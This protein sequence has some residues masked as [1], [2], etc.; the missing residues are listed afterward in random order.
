MYLIFIIKLNMPID[1]AILTKYNAAAK[2]CGKVYNEIVDLINGGE[3]NIVVLCKYG[4]DKIIE[5]CNKIYK[6]EQK[7]IGFPVCITLNDCVGNYL[8]QSDKP[9][10]NTIKN[11]DTIKI[12]LAVNIGGCI[13][14]YG[15]TIVRG[16]KSNEQSKYIDLLDQL[17]KDVI[18]T[19]KA[20]EI[21]DDVRIVLESRCSNN[22]CFPVENCTSYQLLDG[23]I[24]TPESKY[25]VLNHQKYYDDEDN[26][27]VEENLCFEFED[28]E[29]YTINLTII[30][31]KNGDKE[32]VYKEEHDSHIYRFNDY[33]Y[34]LKL[35][36][37]REFC[38]AVKSIHGN[39]AFDITPY[40]NNIKNKMGIKECYENGILES[41]PILYNKDGYHIYHKKFTIIVN[42]DKCIR[43]NYSN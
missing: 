30:P 41:Y 15:N 16:E 1:Q 3:S 22:D 28:S 38:S 12:E 6:K 29:V 2:I 11:G 8:Y 24:Q 23:H 17:T 34:N 43:L 35:K 9:E 14:T 31:E 37:S 5:E 18:D 25:I 36:S 20:G 27:V 4:N 21:N 7:G 39:N 40:R 19:I 10:Y 42:N 33:F 32:H 13:A 26:L